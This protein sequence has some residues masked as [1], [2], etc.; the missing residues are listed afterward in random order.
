MDDGVDR[1]EISAAPI[2]VEVHV[3][4]PALPKSARINSRSTI[5]V[6]NRRRVRFEKLR[7]DDQYDYRMEVD[8]ADVLPV[9]CGHAWRHAGLPPDG[10]FMPK[11]MHNSHDPLQNLYSDADG[12]ASLVMVA[13]NLVMRRLALTYH[14]RPP[15]VKMNFVPPK[16]SPPGWEWVNFVPGTWEPMLRDELDE[17]RMV[18][19]LVMLVRLFYRRDGETGDRDVHELE[20]QKAVMLYLSGT[21][22]TSQFTNFTILFMSLELAVGFAKSK[23]VRP[24]DAIHK[25]AAALLGDAVR[26]GGIDPA[27]SESLLIKSCRETLGEVMTWR[28]NEYRTFNN[29][30]KHYLR[31]NTDKDKDREEEDARRFESTVKDIPELMRRLRADT[32][33]SILLGLEKRYGTGNPPTLPGKFSRASQV[34]LNMIEDCLGRH[35]AKHVDGGVE[36]KI[37]WF[38]DFIE[39]DAIKS[40]KAGYDNKRLVLCTLETLV[41]AAGMLDTPDGLAGVRALARELKDAV[42]DDLKPSEYGLDIEH[43]E[44]LLCAWLEDVTH[45]IVLWM[46]GQFHHMYA[47]LHVARYGRTSR[48]C[49][50]GIF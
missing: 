41:K 12:F 19:A 36:S 40:E 44:E 8:A 23:S 34:I 33:Y 25:H 46:D 15:E 1:M 17:E 16:P 27:G 29:R 47:S 30:L 45:D 6:I 5:V 37:R 38:A 26:G 39:Q 43:D 21:G 42:P 18:Y 24:D 31:P 13:C 48:K 3:H 14:G 32:A 9:A 10:T 11:Y 7:R 35:G 49:D 20:L 4:D 22:G 28:I 2:K 50:P